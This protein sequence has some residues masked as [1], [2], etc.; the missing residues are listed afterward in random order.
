[1]HAPRAISIYISEE[2]AR[3]SMAPGSRLGSV[4]RQSL[5]IGQG[6]NRNRCVPLRCGSR[7]AGSVCRNL[8]AR[9]T[10]LHVVTHAQL[11]TAA[12]AEISAL[13]FLC[14]EARGAR[15]DVHQ[16]LRSLT[17]SALLA[18]FRFVIAYCSSLYIYN[19]APFN[20]CFLS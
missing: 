16:L 17:Y 20:A 18:F 7:T 15:I 1:M 19:N 5:F 12:T 11:S 4:E 6:R 14:A 2:S 9:C 3:A 13:L 8:I 10:C